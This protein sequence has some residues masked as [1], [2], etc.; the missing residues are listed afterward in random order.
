MPPVRALPGGI[1]WAKG[2]TKGVARPKQAPCMAGHSRRLTASDKA[3]AELT[4]DPAVA[5]L[6]TDFSAQA[7]TPAKTAKRS[8]MKSTR[9]KRFV[10]LGL[11]HPAT[12]LVDVRF[13]TCFFAAREPLLYNPKTV[14]LPNHSPRPL[15][16]QPRIS[17]LRT[18]VLKPCSIRSQRVPGAKSSV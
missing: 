4:T 3:V 10:G 6:R 5:E 16:M 12:S 17:A 2:R 11:N 9:S 18:E 14:R 15:L 1:D 13:V 7:V 8:S